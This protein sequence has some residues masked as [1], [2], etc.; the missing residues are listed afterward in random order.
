MGTT[1]L[2][3]RLNYPFKLFLSVA[4]FVMLISQSQ[5]S[6]ASSPDDYCN[7]GNRNGRASSF[8]NGGENITYRLSSRCKTWKFVSSHSGIGLECNKCK[9]DNIISAVSGLFGVQL[10]ENKT[11]HP[12][13]NSSKRIAH[14]KER[15]ASSRIIASGK[16]LEALWVQNDI[17]LED[18]RG[19]SILYK[20]TTMENLKT[21]IDDTDFHEF[22]YMVLNLSDG[23]VNMDT[24]IVMYN[25][26][27]S[28]IELVNSLLADFVISKTVVKIPP[29]VFPADEE[30]RKLMPGSVK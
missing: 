17:V 4:I 23:Y 10:G 22:Y 1:T 9:S 30:L 19:Y 2:N 12:L 16:E 20:V 24:N 21:Q 15:I 25:S 27:K 11:D 7:E 3:L 18:F 5:F 26:P 29:S 6:M 8:Y 14:A 28:P 13:E